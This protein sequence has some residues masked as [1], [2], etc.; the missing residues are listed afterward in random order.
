MLTSP[1]LQSPIPGKQPIAGKVESA[2]HEGGM[3]VK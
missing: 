3:K 2:R 1:D